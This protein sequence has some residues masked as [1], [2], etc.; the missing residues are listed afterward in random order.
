MSVRC[1][2][3]EALI[4]RREAGLDEAERLVLEQHLATCEDCRLL[5]SAM[6]AVVSTLGQ[7]EAPL[8]ESARERAMARAFANVASGSTLARAR[9]TPRRVGGLLAAAAALVVCVRLMSA[10]EQAAPVASGSPT[11]VEGNATKR[12]SEPAVAVALPGDQGQAGR[13][14]TAEAV[15][16]RPGAQ[17]PQDEARTWI[18]AKQRETR[19]FASARVELAPGSRL[20]FREESQTIEL[21]R[22]RVEVDLAPGQGRGLS[23]L[24]RNFRVQVLGTAFAVTPDRV[25]VRRGRVQVFDRGGNVLARELSRGAT[26]TYR[27]RQG[28]DRK[29]PSSDRNGALESIEVASLLSQARSALVRGDVRAAR[30][31]VSR[32]AAG[33]PS[34]AEKAEAR[35][36]EA[37]CA[38]LEHDRAGAIAIYL[39]VAKDFAELPAAENAAFAAAQLTLKAGD[40]ALARARFAAYLERYPQGRFAS[41][42]QKRLESA[43]Q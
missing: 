26:F 13:G 4:D 28:V 38:L 15:D 31:Y 16:P 17:A 7:A 2:D 35:T 41:Q 42:A 36:L 18:E 33:S 20:R 23:V 24:T 12:A 19:E 37:E 39:E 9:S 40:A 6:R 14:T 8:S 43:R 21:E 1:R 11:R 10:P 30:A 22:G 29:V 25:E 27:E 34:R 5:S 32:A 3:V